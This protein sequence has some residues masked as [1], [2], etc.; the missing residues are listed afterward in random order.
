MCKENTLEFVKKG[1][2]NYLINA[3]DN[4]GKVDAT[5]LQRPPRPNGGIGKDLYYL[6]DPTGGT[7]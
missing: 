2:I 7:G 5:E 3:N 6:N 1:V 4:G